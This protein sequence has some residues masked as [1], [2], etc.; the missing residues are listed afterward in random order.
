MFL[1][2]RSETGLRVDEGIYGSRPSRSISGGRRRETSLALEYIGIILFLLFYILFILFFLFWEKNFHIL[3]IL[4]SHLP[5]ILKFFDSLSDLLFF[6]DSLDE[7]FM[8]LRRVKS[9]KYLHH[10]IYFF[11]FFRSFLVQVILFLEIQ[12]ISFYYKFF[13]F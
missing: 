6:N 5:I 13:S 11:F 9:S 1:F 8:I 3:E 10:V 7:L 4:E 2:F 12:K